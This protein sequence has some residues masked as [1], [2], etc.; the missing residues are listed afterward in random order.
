MAEEEEGLLSMTSSMTSSA[1]LTVNPFD[2]ASLDSMHLPAFSPSVFKSSQDTPCSKK[3]SGFRWSIDQMSLLFPADI[4][5][6]P[7]QQDASFIPKEKEEQVQQAINQFFSQKVVVPSPWSESKPMKQVT[8]SPKP[9]TVSILSEHSADNSLCSSTNGSFLGSVSGKVDV[10]CQTAIT[11]PLNFDLEAF[12]GKGRF[13]YTKSSVE[14]FPVAPLRRKLFTQSESSSNGVPSASPLSASSRESGPFSPSI[15]PIKSS[16]ECSPTDYG[17]M[18]KTPN[19]VESQFSSSP[20]AR[21]RTTPIRPVPH[22]Q[23]QA[24]PLCGKM[25]SPLMSP[26]REAPHSKGLP[27]SPIIA[28]SPVES[29]SN[30]DHISPLII[31]GNS[32]YQST[33]PSDNMMETSLSKPDIPE[34][35]PHMAE[36]GGDENIGM[37]RRRDFSQEFSG[38]DENRREGDGQIDLRNEPP[39]K[40]IDEFVDRTD[41]EEEFA[42][43]SIE[44]F[45]EHDGGGGGDGDAMERRKDFTLGLTRELSPIQRIGDHISMLNEPGCSSRLHGTQEESSMD[46]SL[47]SNRGHIQEDIHASSPPRQNIPCDFSLEAS[48]AISPIPKTGDLPISPVR[49]EEGVSK[50]RVNAQSFRS[51]ARHKMVSFH[52][53]TEFSPIRYPESGGDPFSG[54]GMPITS[55]RVHD[56]NAELL[57]ETSLFSLDG[58]EEVGGVRLER[59]ENLENDAGS[60][61]TKFLRTGPQE[62]ATGLESVDDVSAAGTG[63]VPQREKHF[64]SGCEELRENL[65]KVSKYGG[66]KNDGSDCKDDFA[67]FAEDIA[68]H[69]PAK[70]KMFV[71]TSS[72]LDGAVSNSSRSTES[73]D[74]S[75]ASWVGKA[76]SSSLKHGMRSGE[77]SYPFQSPTVPATCLTSTMRYGTLSFNPPFGL[78]VKGDQSAISAMD[79]SSVSLIANASPKKDTPETCKGGQFKQESSKNLRFDEVQFFDRVE[80]CRMQTSFTKKSAPSCMTTSRSYDSLRKYAEERENTDVQEDW[81]MLSLSEAD[82]QSHRRDSVGTLSSSL[83]HHCEDREHCPTMPQ[84]HISHPVFQRSTSDPLPYQ[85]ADMQEGP[86]S[87]DL[88]HSHP[89]QDNPA[90]TVSLQNKTPHSSPAMEHGNLTNLHSHQKLLNDAN[91]HEEHI[92]GDISKAEATPLRPISVNLLAQVTRTGVDSGYN[93][94]CANV[95]MDLGDVENST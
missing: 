31:K 60:K 44:E 65:I 71:R 45:D 32:L 3:K 16:E 66:T 61:V 1:N 70:P 89:A 6:L 49:T 53:G 94:H 40:G 72:A 79:L 39:H 64:E 36:V 38:T 46:T 15:S 21:Y 22:V 42:H 52:I 87:L 18:P 88:P 85:E 30:G 27:P 51:K 86:I 29:L 57:M 83:L 25:D 78:P 9:P 84:A 90:K 54:Q 59:V 74:Q 63:D 2:T 50:D 58:R 14:S 77:Q 75:S 37:E 13:M 56:S 81:L 92:S 41:R 19:S 34:F 91:R 80:D 28:P 4:D 5:E 26:I 35:R 76:C 10:S 55:S 11:L 7:Q 73:C 69:Y 17:R 67:S 48:T 12:L 43:G 47:M 23:L 62:D 95:S 24:S 68:S 33:K 93:T 20:I 82:L 8:F